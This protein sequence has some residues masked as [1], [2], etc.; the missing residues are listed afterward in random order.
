MIQL[1]L[2]FIPN[3]LG[4]TGSFPPVKTINSIVNS[5]E[6]ELK[7]IDPKEL[8]SNLLGDTGL[9]II[10]KKVKKAFNQLLVQ[11]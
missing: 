2:F 5:Y 8:N 7:N 11:V 9:N 6:K 3:P 4:L 10:G 1:G